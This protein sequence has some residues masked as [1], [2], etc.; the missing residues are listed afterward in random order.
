MKKCLSIITFILCFPC[1][2]QQDSI[3]PHF[4][5]FEDKI[6]TQLFILNNSN[7]FTITSNQDNVEVELNP[8]NKTT[9]NIGIQYDIIA[10]SIGFAPKFFDDNNDNNGSR[11]RSF[12]LGFFPGRWV[13]R[14]EYHNQK[15]ISLVPVET[16]G[17]LYFEHMRSTRIGGSTSFF[18]NK[19]FSYRGIALQNVQQ[20]Q[21]AGSFSIGLTYNYT[22]LNAKEEPM[23][24]FK[25]TFFDIAFTPA[26]HY[27][28]VIGKHINLSGGISVG[29]GVNFTNDDSSKSTSPLL[30]SSVLL[31][32]GYN[33]DNW[34]F[35]INVR[36][37][38]FDRQISNQA[39]VGDTMSYSTIFVGYRFDAPKALVSKTKQ[40]KSKFNK[41][42][43]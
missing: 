41:K 25:T 22:E 34:F 20:L 27:N 13:Q 30:T 16:P 35:G 18:F 1:F 21:S 4:R 11:M 24:G 40:L 12:S 14:L 9:L 7:N 8:N 19:K 15:G 36:A 28:W 38:Y 17:S 5:E 43:K 2:A 37:T 23:L 39:S 3:V 29:G 31:A 10:F 32:P 26:Y 42:N 33:S 6:S